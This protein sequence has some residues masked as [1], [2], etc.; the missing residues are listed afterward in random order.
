MK[1]KDPKTFLIALGGNAIIGEKETGTI[2]GQY[3]NLRKT[4]EH[5]AELLGSQNRIVI[6]HGNG[7]QVGNVLLAS[8]VAKNKVP[9]MTLD[10]CGACTQGFMGFMIQNT[11]ANRL[12]EMGVEHNITTVVTQVIVDRNDPAFE[13]PTKPIGPFYDLKEMKILR[14][15]LGWKMI[16]DSNR[17]YRRVV[18]SPIPRKIQQARIIKSMLD[19]G[20]IVIAV[21][22]G[23]IPSVRENN[24]SLH[25]VEVVIDKDYA[26][27]RLAIEIEADVIL[28]LTSVEHVYRDFGLSSQKPLGHL[29]LA[30]ANKLLAEGQF[31]TGSMEPKIRAAIMFLEETDGG[32]PSQKREVIITCPEK[33][34]DALQGKTGTKIT[35]C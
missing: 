12:R 25:G 17:G 22:G 6:T 24:R 19:A 27:S 35:S 21:G 31:G 11:L 33:A 2:E 28:T 30:E 18:P 23:G 26:T 1:K 32:F 14:Q 7:P 34:I 15:E 29:N 16:E 13:N 5:L 20:E 3:L 8:E 4:S 9:L 10:I